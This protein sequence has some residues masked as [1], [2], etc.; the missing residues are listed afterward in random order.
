MHESCTGANNENGEPQHNIDTTMVNTTSLQTYQVDENV[1]AGNSSSTI[2]RH[3]NILSIFHSAEVI[4]DC[5]GY[6][7]IANIT[8]K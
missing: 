4:P 5:L 3:L 6:K 1:S 7:K 2:G 8:T